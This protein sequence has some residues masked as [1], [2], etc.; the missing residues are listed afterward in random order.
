MEPSLNRKFPIV[1]VLW[2]FGV[3]GEDA[4][5]RRW[6]YNAVTRAK[7]RAIVVVEDPKRDRLKKAPFT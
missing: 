6:L 1:I 7:K 5:A 2:P 3:P 4:L